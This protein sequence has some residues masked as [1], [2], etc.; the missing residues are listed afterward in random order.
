MGR[1]VARPRR[2]QRRATRSVSRGLG[3]LGGLAAKHRLPDGVGT[4]GV[5]TEGPQIRYIFCYI[6]LLSVRTR[7]A[8]KLGPGCK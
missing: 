2:G 1:S 8:V 5:F 4:N 6:L 7:C 3:L